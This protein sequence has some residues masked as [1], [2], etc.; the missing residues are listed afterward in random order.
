MSILTI[1]SWFE[2][3]GCQVAMIIIGIALGLGLVLPMFMMG[4]G[5]MSGRASADGIVLFKVLGQDVT[6]AEFDRRERESRSP[7]GVESQFNTMGSIVDR[8]INDASTRQLASKYQVKLS[9]DALRKAARDQGEELISAFENMAKQRGQLK[10]NATAAEIEAALTAV[11]GQSP[12]DYRK[13]READVEQALKIPAARAELELQS[14]TPAIVDAIAARVTVSEADLKASFD[15]VSV[16]RLAFTKGATEAEKRAAAEKVRDEI[17]AGK[18]FADAYKEVTGTA[19]TAP[20]ELPRSSLE[21]SEALKPVAQLKA[22]QLSAIITDFGTPTIFKVVAVKPNLPPD[23]EKN[24]ASLLKDLQ[25]NRASALMQQEL[26]ALR[27][28]SIEWKAKP[29]EHAYKVFLAANRNRS[30]STRETFKELYE[31]ASALVDPT[32]A[33]PPTGVNYLMMAKWTA[34]KLMFDLSTT[35]VQKTLE[36]EK[37]DVMIE[38]LG[39]VEDNTLRFDLADLQFKLGNPAEG[40]AAL[41]EA[42]SNVAGFEPDAEA[43]IKRVEDKVAELRR[44]NALDQEGAK[45][46]LAAT[47]RWRSDKKQWEAEEAQLE[48]ERKE[49]ERRMEEEAKKLE[50]EDRKREEE[51]RKKQ[52]SQTPPSGGASGAAPAAGAGRPA[53]PPALPGA[54]AAPSTSAPSTPPAAAPPA[55]R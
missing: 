11:L 35:D 29:M 25:R 43:F 52:A 55:G 6:A 41:T 3:K 1:R 4:G 5:P 8:F 40:A 15:T 10:P 46:V 53:T 21:S 47:A 30:E 44:T 7:M 42:A 31:G 48:K 51:E 38:V 39:Y 17:A 9:D 49:E 2:H 18:K 20:L 12:A 16:H 27:K 34:F 33:E 23:F 26:E 54:G 24:K 19:L 32:S 14:L 45:E 36:K 13:N 37:L 22:G 28:S 50:E